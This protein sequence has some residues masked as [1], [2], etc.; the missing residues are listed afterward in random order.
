MLARNYTTTTKSWMQTKKRCKRKHKRTCT[1]HES[2]PSVRPCR[3]NMTPQP[4]PINPEETGA[5]PRCWWQREGL[6]TRRGRHE[7]RPRHAF[8]VSS[9]HGTYG[10]KSLIYQGS[11]PG[12]WLVGRSGLMDQHRAPERQFDKDGTLQISGV[13]RRYERGKEG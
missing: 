12:C 1:Y 8:A 5:E 11:S 10:T 4:C 7:V 6:E 9:K 3:C 2:L 13:A